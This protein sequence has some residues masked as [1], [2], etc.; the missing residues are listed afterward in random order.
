[1]EQTNKPWVVNREEAMNRTCSNIYEEY[2]LVIEEFNKKI[3]D[4]CNE[5]KHEIV[6]KTD[7]PVTSK[8]LH[9]FY[10]CLGYRVE[11]EEL[12]Q[13]KDEV[14]YTIFKLKLMW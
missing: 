9:Y 5:R 3:I 14:E 7:N 12:P 4:K 13:Y 1:M 8:D 11:V 6:Y 2:K 10:H